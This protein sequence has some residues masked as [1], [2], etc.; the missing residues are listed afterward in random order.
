M[1]VWERAGEYLLVAMPYSDGLIAKAAGS[2]L[3]DVDGNEILDLAAGQFCAIVGHNHPRLVEKVAA[4]LREAVHL[5]SQYLSPV[6]LEAAEKFAQVAPGGKLKKSLLFSTGTEANECALSIAKMYTGKNG[7]AG[8]SRGYYGLSLGTKSLSSIFGNRHGSGP[9]VPETYSLLT[10]HCFRCPV[11]TRYPECDLLCLRTSLENQ[12]EVENLAA[13]VVEPIISAGGMIVPPPGYLKALKQFAKSHDALLIVDEAQT[14]FGRT[15]RWFGV[16]HHDVEPDILVVSKGAGG[17]FPVSG[18]ITTEEIARHLGR[19]GF[20][21]LASHQSDPI[22]AAALAAVIDIVRE[23]GLVARAEENGAYLRRQLLDVAGRHS[24]VVADVR[25]CGLMLGMELTAPDP[26][27]TAEQFSARVVTICEAKGVHLT[28][29]YFEGVLRFIP[30]LTIAREEID[31]AIDVLDKSI[32]SAIQNRTLSTA[33]L[34]SNRFSHEFIENQSGR[35]TVARMALRLYETTPRYWWKKLSER[36]GKSK[37]GV[38]EDGQRKN[39]DS[40]RRLT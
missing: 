13:I 38:E 4:Q 15:G 31:V 37:D 5:G 34:P 30:A 20:S 16:E 1:E 9:K 7:V 27:E 19:N 36:V 10:P 12:V 39:Q 17:G 21:H 33:L 22:A 14:G 26:A 24:T 40:R 25:G 8:L 11:Q 3:W 32:A 28:Y 2:K 23:E 18:L 6:V 29:S 35:K